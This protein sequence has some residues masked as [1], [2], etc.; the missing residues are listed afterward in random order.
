MRALQ[1]MTVALLA[2][3]LAGT[4]L[5]DDRTFVLIVN[6]KNHVDA[7]DRDFVRDAYLKKRN[8]WSDG[9]VVLPINLE[10]NSPTREDFTREVIRKTRSQL[11]NYWS[12]QIFSG[13]GTPP[14]ETS[15]PEDVVDYVAGH[16]GAIGYIPSDAKVSGVRVVLLR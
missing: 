4:S 7:I 13:K 11:R 14:P 3:A 10:N 8:E 2:V 16:P 1:I 12:Q 9:S 15:T 5:A 6:V